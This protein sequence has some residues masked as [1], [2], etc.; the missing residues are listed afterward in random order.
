MSSVR[1]KDYVGS[2]VHVFTEDSHGKRM[3]AAAEVKY[4]GKQHIREYTLKS[5]DSNYTIRVQATDNHRWILFDGTEV[6]GLNRSDV[7]RAK[8]FDFDFVEDGDP[9]WTRG[10]AHGMVFNSGTQHSEYSQRYF[11]HLHGDEVKYASLFKDID[12]YLSLTTLSEE[13][14]DCVIALN[15]ND[16]NWKRLPEGKSITYMQGFFAGWQASENS[17]P[18]LHVRDDAT[19]TWVINYAPLFGYVVIDHTDTEHVCM[20][21][22]AREGLFSVVDISKASEL[23]VSVYCVTE[24]ETRKFMLS[25]GVITGNCNAH[26]AG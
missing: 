24:P 26:S 21:T 9:A 8:G 18:L 14:A 17:Y 4:Y 3:L 11:I 7:L 25:G 15:I 1:F 2:V 10:F 13:V 23:P 5:F 22:L 16:E 19:A 12:G 6:Y 20:L